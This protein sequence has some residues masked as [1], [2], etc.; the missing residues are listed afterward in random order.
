MLLS[1]AYLAF[2][3]VLRLL[4]ARWRSEFAKDVELL[5]LRH[6]FVVLGQQQARPSFRAADRAFLAALAR[7]LPGRRRRLIVAPADASALASG[8]RAAQA[9]AAAETPGPS[10]GRGSGATARPALSA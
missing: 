8:T 5:V 1:F 10:G 2:T 9:D 6:Q 7:M 4:A 3:A